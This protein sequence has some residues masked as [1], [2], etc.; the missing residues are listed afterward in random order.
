MA[1]I[2]LADDDPLMVDLY[3][4]KFTKLGWEVEAAGDG[5]EALAKAREKRPGLV[6][7]DRLLPGLDGLEV[8]KKLGDHPATKGV[9]VIILTNMEASTAELAEAKALGALDYLIKERIDLGTL[10]DM[11]KPILEKS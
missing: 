1:Y 5:E 6:L 11:I 9:P 7:L 4:R 10:A 2:L 8:L 3:K